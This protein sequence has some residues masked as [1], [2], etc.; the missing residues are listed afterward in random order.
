M[1]YIIHILGY[2]YH[3]TL[4][5]YISRR[6]INE[7]FHHISLVKFKIYQNSAAIVCGTGFVVTQRKLVSI[8]RRTATARPSQLTILVVYCGTTLKSITGQLTIRKLCFCFMTYYTNLN[9]VPKRF[10]TTD[11]FYS[12]YVHYALEKC[13]IIS[14]L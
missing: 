2:I 13:Y 8:Y 7:M 4:T 6:F 14:L 10:H 12:Q 11:V 5:I 1:A 3:I 9:F